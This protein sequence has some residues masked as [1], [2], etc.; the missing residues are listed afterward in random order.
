MRDLFEK[1]L[2]FLSEFFLWC[3]TMN[4]QYHDGSTVHERIHRQLRNQPSP[5]IKTI[6]IRPDMYM[7][8]RRTPIPADISD[9]I[10][11][12]VF[13]DSATDIQR[14]S[15]GK[16]AAVG[17]LAIPLEPGDMPMNMTFPA[18]RFLNVA[19]NPPA[20]YTLGAVETFDRSRN[21]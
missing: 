20:G 8:M 12:R 2:G 14:V 4:F 13:N 7:V 10:V 15:R 18:R 1:L 3:S 19:R 11:D 17:T 6:P 16:L 5:T 9:R 21:N